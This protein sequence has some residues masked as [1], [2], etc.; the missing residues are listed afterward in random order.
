M[1]LA[2]STHQ[3]LS[4]PQRFSSLRACT[5]CKLTVYAHAPLVATTLAHSLS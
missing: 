3:R 2:S 4:R 5:Q 1:S